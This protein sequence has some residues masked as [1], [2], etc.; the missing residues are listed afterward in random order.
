M[1]SQAFK[2]SKEFTV[3]MNTLRKIFASALVLGMAF[4]MV[5]GMKTV[6]AAAPAGSLI[7]IAN[8][9][10]VYY[11]GSNAKRYVFPNE[12]TFK[13][14]YASFSGVQTISQSELES[15]PLGANV[16]M[17][18][19][20][21]LVKITT[22]PS[23]YAVEPGGKLRSIVSEANAISLWGANWASKVR[24]VA[25]SFFTNY[26]ITTPLTAGMYPAGSLVKLST[27]ADVAYFDGTNYRKFASEAAFNANR[28]RFDFVQTAP[29][30]WTS[31]TPMGTDITGAESG[32]IDTSSGAGGSITGSGL[33]V[34]LS[35]DTAAST[36]LVYGQSNANLATFNFTA[37]NDGA[38]IVNSLKIKRTGVSSDAL[39]SAVYLF[40][41]MNRMTDSATVS[42]NYI[43]FNNPNGLFTIPAGQTKKITVRSDISS[44][45]TDGSNV[46]VQIDSASAVTASG[47]TVTGSFP[48]TGN[49]M[50]VVS[51][52]LATVAMNATTL[53]ST[54]TI[55]AGQT[56]ITVWKNSVAVGNRDVKLEGIRLRMIGSIATS[57]LKD[58]KLYVDGVQ[59]GGVQQIGSD[60]YLNF[61]L[62]A[63]PA[64]L[65]AGSRTLEV[66]GN[67]IGGSS[68]DFKF[69]LQQAID[70]MVK[71]SQYDVYVKVTAVPATSGVQTV[72]AGSLTVTK[73]TTS[74]SGNVTKD[75]S[76]ASL[77]KY[78][79]KAYGEPIK[80]EYL[81][82]TVN[83]SDNNVG[84]L[85]NGAIYANGAQIGS[86]SDLNEKDSVA[87]STNYSLGSSLVVTPG[88][89]VTVEIKADI[90][91]ND[92]TNSISDNDTL[93]GELLVYTDG[94]QRMTSLG[95]INVPTAAVVGNT[96]TV[97]TGSLTLAKQASYPNQTVVIP[98]SN[99]KLGSF[100]LTG[101]DIEDVTLNSL[102]VD[103]T[104]GDQF[105]V[106]KLTDVYVKYGAKTSTIKGT[107]TASGNTWSITE[108]LTKNSSMVVEVY[109]NIGNFTAAAGDDTMISSLL[110]TGTTVNSGQSVNTNGNAVLAGQTMTAVASGTIV[111]AVD[112][113][114]P[115]SKLVVAGSTTPVA[116]YKFTT[117]ND[118]Y[119]LTEAV[120]KVNAAGGSTVIG[121]V[122]LKNGATVIATKPLAGT[123]VTFS[124]LSVPVAANGTTTVTAEVQLGTIGFGA[125]TSGANVGL[126]LDSFKANSSQGV[127]ATDGTDRVG[128]AMYAYASIPTITNATLPTTILGGAGTRTIA[129][130]TVAADTNPLAWKKFIFTVLKSAD[131][132]ITGG[133]LWDMS[134]NTEVAGTPTLTTVGATNTSGTIAFVATNEQQVSV[135]TPKTYELR[136]TLSAGDAG[137]YV[138]TNIAQPSAYVAPAAYATVAGTTAS[139]VWSDLSAQSHDATTLDWNNGFLVKNLPTDSQELRNNN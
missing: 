45:T 121:N 16:T 12:A 55:D 47:A 125:G 61:D 126:S 3:L 87:A 120:I 28:F 33:S 127:E 72:A 86:T 52:T 58:L 110:V 25:D 137:D 134:S 105:A 37:S 41:G 81:K 83:S 128:E 27:S 57:D 68:K 124:N 78:E 94:A 73:M 23:V 22:N 88:T 59:K 95:Y 106:N 129:K 40:D 135:G 31:L 60:M 42:Q 17:R 18:P 5:A 138:A 104:A 30:A 9:S 76:G 24:D 75:A 79:F 51:A 91:D 92:G 69:A 50:S 131:P 7:K 10:T 36:T 116:A 132:V 84:K 4:S 130:F 46:G 139:F 114:S 6:N 71:D 136:I 101:N 21:W 89:P 117:T 93:I 111:S 67:L 85:R 29:A 1:Y 11:L 38:A 113:S 43:T 70:V 80:V 102:Q 2:D 20:T 44:T 119:T 13:S 65:I 82:A 109:G 115:V 133:Q 14:W 26:T 100:V 112:A 15:Y 34:A 54:A 49:I 62:S 32:L 8:L 77:A 74:A 64:T 35:S 107:V 96:L 39:L 90:F 108:P 97:K 103:F 19:G 53:P 98:Q 99:Y 123:S 48:M 63:T 56:D 122:T 66:R 118:S